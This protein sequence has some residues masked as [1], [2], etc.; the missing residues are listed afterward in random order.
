MKITIEAA[1]AADLKA[2]PD[3]N[4]LGFGKYF[5][6]HMFV[7]TYDQGQG[8]HNARIVPYADFTLDPAAM[9]LHY[10]QA[11]FE[12]LKAYRDSDD[13]V[14]L[15][16]PLDNLKRMNRSAVRMCM[17]EI[18][19]GAVLETLKELVRLDAAW[20]P[21][22]GGAS[23]YIRPTMVATEAGLGVRPAARYLFFIILSPVGAYYPEG[24]SPVKIFVS[25]KYVRAV[26][27]GVGEVKTAGNYAASIMAAMEAREHGYTQVLWLDAVERKYIEEIGTS[28][29]FFRFADELVTP[30]LSGSILPGITRDSV[31]KM[32]DDWGIRVSQR[33]ISIDE[34]IAANDSGS[35]KEIFATG[36]AAVISP[37]GALSYRG[38]E[39]VINGGSTG[40]LAVRLFDELQ[41]IQYGIRPD[42]HGWGMVI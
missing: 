9:V 3:D 13:R 5:T 10:G 4:N 19:P 15:F 18:D 38:N 37:V 24:F 35:L 25:D 17:P 34:V 21:R 30:P 33:P 39:Y 41:G 7:M 20:V 11:I 1:D 26:R 8:W 16:R 36:T 29:I 6:D 23:L 31:I 2:R 28:N 32:A 22:A 40:D 27:G 42:P 12:G 14:R